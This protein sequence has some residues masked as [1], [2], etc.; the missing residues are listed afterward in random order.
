MAGQREHPLDIDWDNDKFMRGVQDHISKLQARS[1]AD[2]KAAGVK[3]VSRAKSYA[4]VRT[5]FMKNNIV[6]E[7]GRDSKGFFVAVYCRAWYWKMIEF[8]TRYSAA[9]PF[10]RPAFVEAVAYLKSRLGKK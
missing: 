10:M 3:W 1:E 4:A 7:E 6:M 8:G 9:Q 2:V 5:G